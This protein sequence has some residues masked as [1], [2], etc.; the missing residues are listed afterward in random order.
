MPITFFTPEHDALRKSVRR[1][2]EEELAPHADE[3]EEQGDF[4]DWVF[5]RAGELG[6]LGLTYPTEW[7]GQGADYFATIVFG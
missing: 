6:L 5:T 7:G 3:W 1:F 4:P 2:A